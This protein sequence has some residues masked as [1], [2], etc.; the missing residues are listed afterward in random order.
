MKQILEK[1]TKWQGDNTPASDKL[2]H[3]YWGNRIWSL[4]GTVIALVIIFTIDVFF[5]LSIG[6]IPLVLIPSL[7]SLVAAYSKEKSDAVGEGNSEVEDIVYTVRPSYIQDFLLL[8][9]FLILL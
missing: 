9:I 2:A 4:L 5:G 6:L 7:V 3:Y 8:I 1:F